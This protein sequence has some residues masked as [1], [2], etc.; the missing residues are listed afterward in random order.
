MNRSPWSVFSSE[1]L[2]RYIGKKTVSNLNYYLPLLK[3]DEFNPSDIYKRS[4][5]AKI[6]DSF[7]GVDHLEKKSFREEFFS[8]LSDEKLREISLEL[9][10]DSKF[11][12][13]KIITK[14][15]KIKWI[16]SE[17]IEKLFELLNLNKSLIPEKKNST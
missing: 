16:K 14:I 13:K 3:N 15:L 2:E 4:N 8:S 17:Q 5:L 1:D 9:F 6:F 10:E 7:Y 11:D 12:R